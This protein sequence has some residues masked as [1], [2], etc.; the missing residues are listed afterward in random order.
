MLL[1]FEQLMFTLL[2][3]C[4]ARR[5]T[6][7]VI[8]VVIS[9][10]LLGLG[11]VW[12]KNYTSFT[13]IHADE[14]N[15][16]EPLM[17]GT[18]EATRTADYAS[19]AREIIFGEKIMDQIL[20]ESGWLDTNPT[21][22][23]METIKNEVKERVAIHEIGDNLLKIEYRD[24]DP[25]RSFIVA[26]NMADLFIQEGER[27]KIEE[28]EAAYQFIEKQVSEY[29]EKLIVVEEKLREFRSN[30]PDARPGLETEVSQRI[31]TLNDSLEQASL[32]LKESMIRLNSIKDQLSGEAAITISQSREGQYRS[33]IA[34]LQAKLESLRL[35]YK[36]TYPDIVRLNHQIEDLKQSMNIE[37]E[38]QKEARLKAKNSGDTYVD[39]AIIINP[40]YQQLRS[41]S[42]S[43]ETRIATLRARISEL[44]KMLETEYDRA[45]RIHGGEAELSKLTRDYQ[46][47]Q[48]IYQDL[49]RRRE[50]ARVSR[51][52]DQE[53]QGLTFKIQEP[54][55]VPVIPTGLRFLHFA[56]A[57]LCI[58]IAVPV[59]LI[60]IMLQIDPRVRFSNVIASELNLKVLAEI[61]HL[62]NKTEQ[63]KEKQN[64]IYLG[65]GTVML[66]IIYGYVGW[67]KFTG[68]F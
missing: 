52:L 62:S 15:I 50:R 3:E 59:G 39:E 42:S 43:T 30:N 19:N 44:N 23:Q 46:V 13:I 16:L 7:F 26:K 4:Y 35:D 65:V 10:T 29:L 38:R 11:S 48:E 17:Q 21:D 1:P 53:Q 12:P 5:N 45:R 32:Q 60:Y 34:D 64:L 9:L 20:K 2:G 54:A 68:R 41:D 22:V 37:I 47:N 61:T 58:G 56:I 28:S 40:L 66:L 49:L 51:S 63:Q 8:F 14:T 33:K 55:K 57:G 18:A 67:L 25:M 27:S 6:I 24:R 31:N 36:E